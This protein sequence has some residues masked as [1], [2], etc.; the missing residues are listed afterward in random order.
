MQFTIVIGCKHKQQ[1]K[2]MTQTS[3]AC[4]DDKNKQI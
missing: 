4:S 3:L 2:S 1:E